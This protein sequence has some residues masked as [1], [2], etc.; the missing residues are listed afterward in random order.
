MKG[1][2]HKQAIKLIHRRQ[3]AL[4]KGNQQGLLE[5]HLGSCNSCRLYSEEME[6]LTSRLTNEFQARLENDTGPSKNVMNQVMSNVRSISAAK[7][8][9]LQFQFLT[10]VIV[11]VVLAF[12]MNFVISKLQSTSTLSNA[13]IPTSD[14]PA[15]SWDRPTKLQIP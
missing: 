13:G 2:T 7:R 5:E 3:D 12:T 11:L 15:K 6:Q 9:S 10:G 1:I 8:T 14:V 4:L